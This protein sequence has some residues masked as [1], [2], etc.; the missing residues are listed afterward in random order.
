MWI[1][2]KVYEDLKK[3][4]QR[5]VEALTAWIEQ[6]SMQVG[7]PSTPAP[8]PPSA[9]PMPVEGGN[10]LYMSDDEADLYEAHASG[11]IND[12]QLQEGLKHAGFANTEL[13]FNNTN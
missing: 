9:A 3:E 11:L 13:T 12:A 8:V 10:S 5:T 7:Q 4:H 1:S 2:R 6:L